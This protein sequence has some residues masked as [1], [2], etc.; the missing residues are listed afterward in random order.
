MLPSDHWARARRLLE[1]VMA[2]PAEERPGYLAAA[3]I[4]EPDIRREVESLLRAHDEAGDFL[5][6]TPMRAL[7]LADLRSVQ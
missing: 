6:A 7:N 4:S 2:R 1:E 5:Q 3:S